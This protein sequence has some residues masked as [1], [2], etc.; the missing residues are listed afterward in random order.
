[1]KTDWWIE[2]SVSQRSFHIARIG[3]GVSTNA[4][5]FFDRPLSMGDWVPVF[6]GTRDQCETMVLQLERRLEREEEP[7]QWIH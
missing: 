7:K 6:V 4:K 5:R 2:Y 1:M 3:E